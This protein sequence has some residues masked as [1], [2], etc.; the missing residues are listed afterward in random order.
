MEKTGKIFRFQ[1]FATDLDESAINQ[2]REGIFPCGIA[3]DVAPE[4]REW[5]LKLQDTQYRINKEIRETVIFATQNLIQDPPFTSVDLISSR[6]LLIYLNAELQKE[7][8]S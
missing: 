2:V 6:N 7:I 8:F 5:F 4:H 3:A 1:I